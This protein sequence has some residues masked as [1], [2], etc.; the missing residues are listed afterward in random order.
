MAEFKVTQSVINNNIICHFKIKN[1]TKNHDQIISEYLNK[2]NY[3]KISCDKM[4]ADKE[5]VIRYNVCCQ[6]TR[7]VI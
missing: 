4:T 6:A 1:E 2:C 5:D 3:K 7:F